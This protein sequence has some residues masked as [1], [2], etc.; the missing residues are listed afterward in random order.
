MIVATQ[1]LNTFC[2]NAKIFGWLLFFYYLQSSYIKFGLVLSGLT[3]PIAIN[4]PQ[5]WW[6]WA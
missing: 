5:R 4:K 1:T 6:V 2:W 3:R